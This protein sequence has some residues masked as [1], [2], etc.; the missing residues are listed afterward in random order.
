MSLTNMN[1][2]NEILEH[3]SGIEQVKSKMKASWE[4][5]NYAHFA[6]FMQN[7]A[8]EVLESWNIPAKTQLLDVACGSGQTAIPAAQRGINVT[9]V[10]IARNLIEFARQRAIEEGLE[11]FFDEGDAEELPYPDQSFDTAIT[12]F[13]A[14]F[15]PRPDQVVTELSRVLRPRGK[16]Y[17]ANWT[18]D[19]MP[20]HMFKAVAAIVPPPAGSTPPVLWG[21]EETVLKRLSENFTDIQLTRKIY[22]Q[23][24]YPFDAAELVKL[25][26]V[27]FGPVKKAFD[28]QDTQGQKNLSQKLEQIYTSNC[29]QTASGITITGGEYLEV[30]ATRI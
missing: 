25:F 10:D 19:S 28:V 11:I 21:D 8:I 29:E 15:A 30:I 3:V 27:N 23:W 7:G 14:M 1:T 16:L 22:P 13:G 26:R 24:H 4:D 18:Q 17:M 12:M 20:A 6:S 2:N 9:G 5:G